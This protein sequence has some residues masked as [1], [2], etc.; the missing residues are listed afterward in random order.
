[1]KT[2]NKCNRTL[3]DDFFSPHSAGN[4]GRPECKQCNNKLGKERTILRNQYGDPPEGYLCPICGRN[5]EQVKGLGG[6]KCK[7]W[8]VDHDHVTGKFRGWL[9]HGCNRG[10]GCFKDNAETMGRG[11]IYLNGG[12]DDYIQEQIEKKAN[13]SAFIK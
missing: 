13:L 9:C 5:E 4:Y 7:P 1:M 12:Y 10:V 3:S 11:I 6:K 8:V 2:C